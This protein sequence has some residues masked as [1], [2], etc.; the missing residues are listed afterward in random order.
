MQKICLVSNQNTAFG[1]KGELMT[2]I[3]QG[4]ELMTAFG[5]IGLLMTTSG[6]DE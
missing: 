1:Q 6:Q 5:Q 3:E 2:T 4:S